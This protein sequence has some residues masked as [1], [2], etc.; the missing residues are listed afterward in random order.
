MIEH[1]RVEQWKVA[2]AEGRDHDLRSNYVE[3]FWLPVLGPTATLLLRRLA[4]ELDRSPEG[5][6]LSA[7]DMARSLGLGG[8]AGRHGPFPRRATLH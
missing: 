5:F 6:D 3:R 1:L 7:N 2:W 4:Y 8:M